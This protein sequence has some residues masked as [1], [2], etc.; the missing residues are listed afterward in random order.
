MEIATVSTK[1]EDYIIQF[2]YINSQFFYEFLQYISKQPPHQKPSR[3]PQKQRIIQ[4]IIFVGIGLIG[5]QAARLLFYLIV[6]YIAL[7]AYQNLTENMK[8]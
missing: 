7:A 4:M 6:A 1:V 3:I 8:I 2:V 5:F